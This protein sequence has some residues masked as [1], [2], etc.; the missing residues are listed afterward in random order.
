MNETNGTPSGRSVITAAVVGAAVG[1]GVALLLA[2]CSGRETRGWLARR[3]RD[4]KDQTTNAIGQ[5]ASAVRRAATHVGIG[6]R[7][8]PAGNDHAGA[9]EPVTPPRFV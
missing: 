8:V 6:S 7:E 9:D 2:P 1:A 5:G 3:T 4:I